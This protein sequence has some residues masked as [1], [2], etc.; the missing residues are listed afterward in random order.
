MKENIKRL[1]PGSECYIPE[2]CFVIEL[3]NSPDDPDVSIARVR[4]TPGVT[5]RWHRLKGTVERYIVIEG[6][7]RAEIGSLPP[8]EVAAGDVVLIPSSCR[9]RIANIGQNDLVFLAVCTPRF[10][11]EAYEDIDDDSPSAEAF[12]RPR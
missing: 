7:G 11:N 12:V 10:T 8:Q 3:S 2:R 4:V 1:D 5:T 9:Q 6:Q